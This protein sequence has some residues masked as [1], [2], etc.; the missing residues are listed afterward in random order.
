MK[1]ILT[2]FVCLFSVT[3]VFAQTEGSG[4]AEEQGIAKLSLARKDA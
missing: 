3:F 1:I 2:V 4:T